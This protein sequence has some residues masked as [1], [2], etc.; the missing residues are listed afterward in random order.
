MTLTL[1]GVLTGRNAGVPRRESRRDR[2]R[3]VVPVCPNAQSRVNGDT[4]II[5]APPNAQALAPGAAQQVMI[6]AEGNNS[7]PASCTFDGAS[8]CQAQQHQHQHQQQHHE[9]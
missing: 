1:P 6:F 4:L 7:N 9:C 2:T 8:V 5:N 3:G